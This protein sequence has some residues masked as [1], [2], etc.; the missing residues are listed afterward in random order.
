MDRDE[1]ILSELRA[2]REELREYANMTT[3]NANDIKWMKGSIRIGGALVA[4]IVSAVVSFGL[5][6]IVK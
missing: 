2:L 3:V 4:A 1:M 6:Y 5:R